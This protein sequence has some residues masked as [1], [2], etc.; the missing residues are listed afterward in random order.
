MSSTDVTALLG[1]AYSRS[2]DAVKQY[3]TQEYRKQA[4]SGFQNVFISGIYN[5]NTTT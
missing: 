4:T 5:Y 3:K 1:T 2:S